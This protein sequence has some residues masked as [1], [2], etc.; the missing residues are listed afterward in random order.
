MTSSA[1]INGLTLELKHAVAKVCL[2][3]TNVIAGNS[4]L[5]VKYAPAR[6]FNAA[7]GTVSDETEEKTLTF[8]LPEA[9][10]DATAAT[11]GT[12]IARFYVLAP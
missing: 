9:G 8:S 4:S 10:V 3:E 2:Y 12:R 7:D 5:S 1:D 11:G 6:T